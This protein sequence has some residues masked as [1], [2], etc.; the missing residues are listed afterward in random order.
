[1]LLAG[2]SYPDDASF[3]FDV[4]LVRLNGAGQELWRSYL[5][6]EKAEAGFSVRETVEGQ[7]LIAGYGYNYDAADI[8]GL[9]ML[10]DTAGQEMWRRYYGQPG[11]D[12]LYDLRLLAGGEC[13][14]AGFSG[15]GDGSQFLLIRDQWQM[16]DATE[17]LLP[18]KSL[19]PN[20]VAPGGRVY[21]GN[22]LLSEGLLLDMQGKTVARIQAAE[23]Y[24]QVPDLPPGIYYL[25]FPSNPALPR[26]KLRVNP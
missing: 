15:S 8:D 14:A 5:G 26:Q 11:P 3:S 7:L 12:Y 4:L 13:V 10:V 2:E 23:G 6:N 18:Q 16:T 19:F 20:P 25:Y 1:M 24:F 9:L 22:A 17:P 21:I